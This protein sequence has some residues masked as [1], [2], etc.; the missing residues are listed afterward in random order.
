M[1]AG[2]TTTVTF[3]L[4]EAASDFIEDD[5]SVSGGELSSFASSSSTVYTATFTPTAD[6]TTDGVISV[7]SSKFSD[8]AGNE[9]A[10]GSEDNNSLTLSVDTVRPTIAITSDASSLKA[11]ETTTVTFTL[12][13]AASDF[14]EDDI[15]VSGGELS[16]FASSSS[17]VYTATFT[18][19]AD[20]TTD[21][22]ISVASSKF[23]DSAGNENADGS[24]DNNTLTLSVDTVRP[25]IEITSEPHH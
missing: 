3:T 1:K 14:I 16:D 24:E 23:S 19:T 25:T 20:S 9:N 15:S 22:V 18:L 12:S 13:E 17:T 5:I 10:D 2:E 4:S 7:A 8:S 21:G 6:S 11:G